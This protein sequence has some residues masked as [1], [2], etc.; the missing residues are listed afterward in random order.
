MNDEKLVEGESK[1]NNL[2]NEKKSVTNF[3][4]HHIVN[5]DRTQTNFSLKFSKLHETQESFSKKDYDFREKKIQST[6]ACFFFFFFYQILI[7]QILS[8]LQRINIKKKVKKKIK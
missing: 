7:L 2:Q 4:K 3:K 6:E 1:K 8:V 5:I